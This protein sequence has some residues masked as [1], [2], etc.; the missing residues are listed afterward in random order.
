MV[1]IGRTFSAGKMNKVVDER[2]VP[3]GEYIDARNMR[4]GSTEQAE[5]GAI[6]LTKG[7]SKI[8]D[9]KFN[10]TAPSPNSTTIG[11]LEDPANETIYWFINDTVWTGQGAGSPVTTTIL[12]MVVSYN[13]RTLVTRYHLVS[14]QEGTSNRST[15]NFNKNYLITGVNLVDNILLWTDNYNPPRSINVLDGYDAPTIAAGVVTST[16]NFSAEEIRVIVKP[17]L[18]AP[19]VSMASAPDQ[20]NF[21]TERF[22]SFAYRYKYADGEYSATSQFSDAAFIPK[23]F[24]FSPQSFVNEGMTNKFNMANITVNTGSSLVKE[25]EILWKDNDNGIIK[26]MENLEKAGAYA[27]NIDVTRSFNTSKILTVLPSSEILRLY[28]NVPRFAKAQTLMGNRLVYG[29]YVENYDLKSADSVSAPATQFTYEVALITST[30]G[31]TVLPTSFAP[32]TYTLNGIAP[33]M[34]TIPNTVLNIDMQEVAGQMGQGSV[35]DINV[36]FSVGY[37]YNTSFFDSSGNS[38][39]DPTNPMPIPPSI[40]PNCT[41]TDTF[42]VGLFYSFPVPFSGVADLVANSNFISTLTPTGTFQQACNGGTWT[43]IFSCNVPEAYMTTLNPPVLPPYN[44]YADATMITASG[45]SIQTIASGSTLAIQFPS[46][47]YNQN[48]GGGTATEY[49]MFYQI[50]SATVTFYSGGAPKSLHSNRGY[51]VGMV[52]MDAFKRATTAFTSP[53]NVIH[54]G[55][56]NSDTQ[57]SIQVTIPTSQVPPWWATTYKFVIKPSASTYETIFANLVFMEAGSADAYILLQGENARKVEEGQRLIVKADMAGPINNCRYVTVLEKAAQIKGFISVPAGNSSD[58]TATIEAPAGV[59]M[60]IKSAGVDLNAPPGSIIS[61]GYHC[62]TKN[63]EGYPVLKLGGDTDGFNQNDPDNGNPAWDIPSGS[64]IRFDFYFYRK[65]SGTLNCEKREYLWQPEDFYAGDNYVDIIDWYLQENIKSVIEANTGSQTVGGNDC[66][67]E[68]FAY[69]TDPVTDDIDFLNGWGDSCVNAWSFYRDPADPTNPNT[70]KLLVRGTRSCPSSS[71]L[72]R[73]RSKVCGE[74]TIFRAANILI[75]E[76]EPE[77]A[78][79]DVWY[80]G[81]DNYNITGGNHMSG[82]AT[83]DVDQDIS[84]GVPAQVF[85]GNFNCY[86]FGNG[87]E[88]YTIRDSVNGDALVLGNR[89]TATASQDYGRMH[90]YA[91]LTYSGVYN[92]ES[93]VNKLNEFNLG[94]LNFK[95]LDDSFGVV[96]KLVGRKSDILVLQEDKISYVLAGKNLLSDSTGGGTVTA[97]PVVLGTQIARLEAYGISN[98]PESYGEFG[99]DKYF[100]DVKRG[101][102]IQLKGGSHSNEVLSVVSEFGMRSWFRDIFNDPDH[103]ASQLLGAYDPYMDEYVLSITSKPLPIDDP[104]LGCGNTLNFALSADVGSV[105]FCVELGLTVGTVTIT[106]DVGATIDATWNSVLYNGITT[107]TFTKSS[108]TPSYVDIT[109]THNAPVTLVVGCPVP[110]PL[111]ICKVTVNSPEYGTPVGE[112][113]HNQ[114]NYTTAGF[115]SITSPPNSGPQTVLLAGPDSITGECLEF[116]TSQC[117]CEDGN[118]GEGAFPATGNTVSIMSTNVTGVD[119]FEY[120]NTYHD[121]RYWRTDSVT[122]PLDCGVFADV[123]TILSSSTS[124]GAVTETV[125]P[126]ATINSGNFVMPA[127]TAGGGVDT[128]YLVYDYRVVKEENLCYLASSGDSESDIEELCCDC[129]CDNTTAYYEVLTNSVAGYNTDGSPQYLSVQYTNTDGDDVEI[130]LQPGFPVT[131]CILTTGTYSTPTV[132]A[133]FEGLLQATL[134]DCGCS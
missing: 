51:E 57:N 107:V 18:K 112:T 91:D 102:V 74:V 109:L 123:Q 52:Y 33:G 68:N 122:S 37:V 69:N 47:L 103:N 124:V 132:A 92:D 5:I 82:V 93:N 40:C 113:V 85:L 130:F 98:N 67:V 89:V 60:K 121:L 55:C 1:K 90:R 38:G 128:L 117:E 4:L 105:S 29:N 120:N 94:L 111:R 17:P 118:Q 86:T 127:P 2:L 101:A 97:T 62:K 61:T 75:F 59:Y 72:P 20:F 73:N 116:V 25:V 88:S 115:T 78:L 133:G 119:T 56:Q 125:T 58:E 70:I 6:E 34:I 71:W 24:A 80:E 12:D 65:G 63:S 39:T 79:P 95:P 87:C 16:D 15:L 19:T 46:V 49:Q 66:A 114:H 14:V 81:Q 44:L 36:T 21:L 3:P 54:V 7:N 11:A 42:S 10:G 131:I 100:T 108:Q 45:D 13:T 43:D 35:L 76:T 41:G 129:Q 110:L 22:I 53:N 8:T 104:C 126:T 77:D 50:T 27:N 96:Q 134:L 32:G 23:N 64:R 83:G 31:E 28:D 30:V 9:I 48:A 84:A 99:Y 106:A 26:I